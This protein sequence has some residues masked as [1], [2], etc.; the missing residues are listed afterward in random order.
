MAEDK[1]PAAQEL[2]KRIA[3]L[4]QKAAPQLEGLSDRVTGAVWDNVK[5]FFAVLWAGIWS[6]LTGET[7]E[8][9]KEIGFGVEEASEPFRLEQITDKIDEIFT[10]HDDPFEQVRQFEAFAADYPVVGWIFKFFMILLAP[11][12][13]MLSSLTI[14]KE[15]GQQALLQAIRPALLPLE[16]FIAYAFKNPD[17]LDAIKEH[18]TRYGFSDDFIEILFASAT[19]KLSPEEAKQ[20]YLRENIDEF[21]HDEIM[22]SHRLGDMAIEQRKMLYEIIPPVGDL[23]TMA[24]REVFSPD[25]VA[26]FGQ[27]ED[28]PPEFLTH[29]KKVG[30]TEEWAL[31]YWA[32]HWNLPGA[33]QGF[34]MLHRGVIEYEDLSLLLRALDI[35]P[36][37]RDKL[38]EIAYTPLTRVDV[39][40][41]YALGI[42]D[43]DGV[44]KSY[45][46]LGY[47]E[48]NAVL[49]TRFTIAYTTER[50]R[51]LTRADITT[52]FKRGVMS[53]DEALGFLLTMGYSE[54]NAAYI[55]QRAIF[56]RDSSIKDKKIKATQK[57]YVAGRITETDVYARLGKLDMPSAEQ[58]TLLELWDLERDAK[59]RAFTFEQIKKLNAFAIIT[60]QETMTELKELGYSPVDSDR[61][62]QLIKKEGAK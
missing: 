26:R 57:L 23:I 18:V 14:R 59:V 11:T 7:K 53:Q 39:R 30:L 51:D 55:V 61:L 9:I 17:S 3:D 28:F 31:N 29:A 1:S 15:F 46:D 42:L 27:L 38:I 60:D 40:R 56:E 13:L 33:N 49:M 4:E 34:E 43:E 25:V 54:I 10:K 12:W 41:M 62:L 6:G 36:F 37:W 48:E 47:N 2:D 45:M 44:I 50:E 24:V 21:A 35:M 8:W 22:K 16:S 19:E 32:A 52:L 58:N 20:A 5:D